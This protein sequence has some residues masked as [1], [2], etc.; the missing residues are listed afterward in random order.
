[1]DRV[2]SAIWDRKRLF[3]RYG[4]FVFC[5]RPSLKALDY[6]FLEWRFR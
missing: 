5:G 4:P 3:L 6:R 2:R 1:M